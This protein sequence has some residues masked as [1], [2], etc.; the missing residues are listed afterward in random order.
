MGTKN[1]PGRFDCYTYAEPD[2]PMFIVL[3]RDAAGPMAVRAWIDQRIA[4]GKNKP[5]DQ[6]IVDAREIADAMEQYRASR[7]AL[8]PAAAWPFPKGARS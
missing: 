6:Q 4:S 3:G 1:N 7:T 5:D 2:E 8:N